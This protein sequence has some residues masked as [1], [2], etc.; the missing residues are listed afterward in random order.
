MY[1]DPQ[2]GSMPQLGGGEGEAVLLPHTGWR[3]RGGGRGVSTHLP[4]LTW[5]QLPWG[6]RTRP[7]LHA[8]PMPNDPNLGLWGRRG[9]MSH[10]G[11]FCQQRVLQLVLLLLVGAAAPGATRG[12]RL[13]RPVNATVA[14][15]KEA[16]PLC[17]TFTTAICSG[18]C[19]TKVRPLGWGEMMPRVAR[20]Q[21]LAVLQKG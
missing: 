19:Q 18:Y 11:A 17:I 4:L 9:P 21:E 6:G 16:C 2:G 14:A 5:Y 10:P 15:E 3:S 8:Y 7:L 20:L 1:G 12:R 13:C